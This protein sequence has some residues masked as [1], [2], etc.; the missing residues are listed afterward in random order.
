MTRSCWRDRAAGVSATS[1]GG[2]DVLVGDAAD[3]W[4]VAGS[5]ST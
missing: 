5:G 3:N 1:N 2:D 4:L